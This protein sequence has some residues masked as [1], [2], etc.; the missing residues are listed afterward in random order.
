MKSKFEHERDNR[1]LTYLYRKPVIPTVFGVPSTLR[2]ML[3]HASP[4]IYRK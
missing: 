1:H 3:M 2:D 4:R